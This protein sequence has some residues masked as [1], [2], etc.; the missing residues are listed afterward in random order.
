MP[1]SVLSDT[2]IT[3]HHQYLLKQ[4]QQFGE[5]KV[6]LES[7]GR[8]FG[9]LGWT[10]PLK[11][12]AAFDVTVRLVSWDVWLEPSHESGLFP[13]LHR[14]LFIALSLSLLRNQVRSNSVADTPIND[15]TVRLFLSGAWCIP[16]WLPCWSP[17][18]RSRR[19]SA[20]SWPGRWENV[21]TLCWQFGSMT[22]KLSLNDWLW[23]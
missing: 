7:A 20:S 19:A 15:P 23:F 21:F 2:L 22:F 6:H 16:P 13:L 5:I 17:P 14:Q 4:H 12:R 10:V 18:S 8:V 1:H 9:Y 3:H 11:T